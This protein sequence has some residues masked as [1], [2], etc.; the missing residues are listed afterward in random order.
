MYKYPGLLKSTLALLFVVLFFHILIAGRNFLYPLALSILLAFLIYPIAAKLEKLGAPRI[1]ANILSIL[2]GIF[3]LVAFSYVLATQMAI[4][5]EDIP[6]MKEQAVNNLIAVEKTIESRSGI[7]TQTQTA[8]IKDQVDNVFDSGSTFIS[9]AFSATAGTVVKI[10]L[11]PVFVF[12]LLYYRNKFRNFIF[13]IVPAKNHHNADIIMDEIGVLTKRYMAGIF[14]VVL[15]LCILNTIGLLIVGL[16]FALFLGIVSALFNFIPYFGTLIGGA[17]P[18]IF[19]ILT[20]DSPAYAVGVVILFIIIQFIE[21]NILTPN[22][23]GDRVSIN[24][25]I[26]ILSLIVGSMVWGI[27][28]MFVA[29]PLM[30]VIKIICDRVGNLKP[31]AY[32]LGTEGTERHAITI[33]RIRKIFIK[34]EIET[35]KV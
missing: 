15:I 24:P 22:I 30:G 4:F 26:I 3:I 7:A 14:L 27:P 28:G 20:G 32:L 8:W 31:F 10:M 29:V 33:D 18:L 1:L 5:L 11:M 21:N 34:D 2:S 17:V 6:A 25:F 35:P 16:K 12:F 13:Q 19:A 23:V 9:T